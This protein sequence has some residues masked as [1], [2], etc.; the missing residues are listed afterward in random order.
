[1]FVGV[2][3][4]VKIIYPLSRERGECFLYG[5]TICEKCGYAYCPD[6]AED[7]KQ[8]KR[9]CQSWNQPKTIKNRGHGNQMRI[10][11]SL[12]GADYFHFYCSKCNSCMQIIGVSIEKSMVAIINGRCPS[13]GYWSVRKLRLLS[14]AK[15]WIDSRLKITR[16]NTKVN[17]KDSLRKRDAISNFLR[18]EILERD[19]FTC[20][21]CGHKDI[22]KRTLHVDHIHPVAKGGI[23]TKENLITACDKCNNGK[24]AK[25]LRKKRK[26]RR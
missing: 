23:T 1:M 19:N 2:I 20:Q 22:T 6:I 15:V 4:K 3:L 14:N 16:T 8:H 21:Y 12:L 11:E 17:R 7:R 24:G 25:I 13:C 9:Y 18:F 26:V 10:H 5:V